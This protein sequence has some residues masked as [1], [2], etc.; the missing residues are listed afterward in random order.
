M[1][2]DFSK[3][4]HTTVK[5]DIALQK[6]AYAQSLLRQGETIEVAYERSGYSF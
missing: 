1:C 3:N 4:I 6:I 5:A 2:P